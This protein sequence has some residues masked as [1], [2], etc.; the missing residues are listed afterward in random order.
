MAV[1]SIAEPATGGSSSSSIQSGTIPAMVGHSA[2][3]GCSEVYGCRIAA[4]EADTAEPTA[5]VVSTEKERESGSAF[6]ENYVV[7]NIPS[8][9]RRCRWRSFPKFE[10]EKSDHEV[11]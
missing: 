1:S 3:K 4:S 7:D 6:G 10:N 2:A 5:A 11:H 8:P 9:E